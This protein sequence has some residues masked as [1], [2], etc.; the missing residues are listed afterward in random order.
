MTTRQTPPRTYNVL[1]F[2]AVPDGQT[3]CTET[4]QKALD[5]CSNEGGGTIYFPGGTYKAGSLFLRDSVTLHLEATARLLQSKDMGD[6]VEADR[7]SHIWVTGSRSAFFYGVD[8]ENVSIEGH[9]TIDGNMALCDTNRG[10][11]PFHFQKC[12]NVL[13]KDIR[14]VNGP[15]WSVTFFEC[16]HVAIVGVKCIDSYADGINCVSCRNVLYD[17]VFISGSGDDPLCIKNDEEG[18][19]SNFATRNIFITNSTV[20]N[21][22]HPAIKIGTGTA[23]TFRNIVVSN[24]VFE[25]TGVVFCI[26]LMRPERKETPERVIENVTLSNITA[27]NASSLVD[28]TSMDV[29][30]PVIRNISMNNILA[31]IGGV[32]A[33]DKKVG[34]PVHMRRSIIAGLPGAPVSNVTLSDVRVTCH[35]EPIPCWLETRFVN[36]LKLHNVQLDLAGMVDSALSYENGGSLDLDSVNID[37]L[38]GD[39]PAIMLSQAREVSVHNCRAPVVETFLHATGEHTEDICFAGNDL[40]R[41][42]KPFDAAPEVSEAAVQPIAHGIAYSDLHVSKEIGPNEGFDAEVTLTNKANAGAPRLQVCV[43]GKPAGATWVWLEAGESRQ[44]TL[45]TEKYYRPGD[46]NIETGPLRTTAA[47]KPAPAAFEFGEMMKIV[48]P[49]E[50]GQLASVTV[51]VKNVGGEK[52]TKVVELYA[53]GQVVACEKITL[54]AGQEEQVTIEHTFAEAGPRE[55]KAGDFPAWPFATFAN[56]TANFYQTREKIIIEAGGGRVRVGDEG[57]EYAGCYLKDIAG[58]F[59]VTAQLLSQTATGPYA[60]AGLMVRNDITGA[61]TS[62]GYVTLHIEPKYGAQQPFRVDLDGDGLMDCKSGGCGGRPMWFKLEKKGKQFSAWT[63]LDG[64]GWYEEYP[65]STYE[66]PSANAVQD[67]GLFANAFSVKNELTRVEFA[68]FKVEKP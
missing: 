9:G 56:T 16:D 42:A 14:V 52:G 26:Q 59:V 43:D 36:G 20:R 13:L 58:D 57:E 4:I 53:D 33:T 3:L 31:E 7:T 61:G 63:S 1:D 2:G 24:C 68:H 38:A 49:A 67:V 41:A 32:T 27:R 47:V 12:R 40:S 6:Y 66:V 55:F 60:G 11:L 64:R 39:G 51:P 30:G 21:T 15:G 54:E 29:T 22:T 46:Y 25:N 5:I 34:Y 18:V 35:R 50:A 37:G 19:E 17:G 10:P 28:I 65:Q 62:A 45:A 8:V 44:V 48:S 23:G